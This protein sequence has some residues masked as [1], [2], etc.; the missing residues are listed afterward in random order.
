MDDNGPAMKRIPLI[1]FAAV[2]T[3]ASIPAD[4]ASVGSPYIFTDETATVECP[5]VPDGEIAY[6]ITTITGE[7][8]GPRTAGTAAVKDGIVRIPPTV[9]G[10]HIVTF[11]PPAS[12]EVRFLAMEPPSPID[13]PTIR[14]ALPR[15][16]DKLLGGEAFRIV[17]MGDS[18][19]A[20]GD[21]VFMLARILARAAGNTNVTAVRHAYSGRSID[22]TVRHFDRDFRDSRPDLGVL[23]YGLN[24]EICLA[25][26]DGFVEQAEWTIREMRE[27]FGADMLLLEATP[28]IETIRTGPDGRVE[29]PE[30]ATRTA[31]FN[32]ATKDLAARYGLPCANAFGA[33]WGRG[34]NSLLESAI[35][36]WPRYPFSYD[37]Q[38]TA[39]VENGGHGDTI[40]PNALGH[41]LIARASYE[42]LNGRRAKLALAFSG[43]TS[44]TENGL[45]AHVVAS[46]ATDRARSGRLDAYA[47][48][49]ATI[50]GPRN[51][52][53]SLEPGATLAFDVR[54]IGVEKAED[55][56]RFP[57]PDHLG[58]GSMPF[59]MVDYADGGSEVQ[60]VR[61]PFAV[62]GGFDRSRREISGHEASIPF[63]RPDGTEERVKVPIPDA[64]DVGRIPL[65]KPLHGMDGEIRWD[66]VDLVYAKVASAPEGEAIVDGDLGEWTD[67]SPF[68][69][70]LPCQ[71]RSSDGHRDTRKS[72]DEA[73]LDVRV[74]AGE[75]GLYMA[76]EGTGFLDRDN[77]NVFFDKRAPERIGSAGPY[78]WLGLKFLPDGALDLGE[79]ETSRPGQ[80]FRGAWRKTNKGLDAEIF[81][82]YSLFDEEAWPSSGDLGLSVVWRHTHEDRY[83]R[84]VW[85]E[86]GNEWNSRWYGT[87]RKGS[88]SETPSYIIRLW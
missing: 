50:E 13:E 76:F 20:T 21:H 6:G 46:N 8:F 1:C 83:T 27:R 34:A 82:P 72:V 40:H 15:T 9:C 7:G 71:A 25:P 28:H 39:M 60:G 73:Y 30:F 22:A 31:D 49:A 33:I 12:A 2:Y 64:E 75:K 3:A 53:Y 58:C 37:R 81:V 10:I 88:P 38:L 16:A 56:T 36:M 47:P 55:L 43:K 5:D 17:G 26:R 78:F 77:A 41:Y 52:P 35:A 18:V 65:A 85:F 67:V 23:M 45:V 11:A 79:G 86:N 80:P 57:H 59:T 51:L 87:V 66:A 54:W 42:A 63:I 62:S 74:M 4:A 48:T 19:T 68:P 69:V 29:P 14:A 61:C 44:W 32:L 70:G 24:D 84:L